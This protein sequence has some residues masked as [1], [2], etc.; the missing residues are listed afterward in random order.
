MATQ[1]LFQERNNIAALKNPHILPIID[2]GQ[3]EVSGITTTCVVT[4]YASEGSVADWLKKRKMAPF[5]IQD[6]S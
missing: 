5:S 4:P 2:C 3:E 6:W 1:L